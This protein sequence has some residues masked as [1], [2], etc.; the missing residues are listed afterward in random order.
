MDKRLRKSMFETSNSSINVVII[1]KKIAIPIDNTPIYSI[2]KYDSNFINGFFE[3]KSLEDKI[4]YLLII[5]YD[6]ALYNYENP[7]VLITNLVDMLKEKYNIIVQIDKKIDIQNND[8]RGLGNIDKSYKLFDFY[9]KILDD[10]T[11]LERYL[12][13]GTI[14]VGADDSKDFTEYLDTIDRFKYDVFF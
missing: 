13:G 5:A 10:E 2:I 12:F 14:E 4:R 8:I 6:F 11:F 1:P 9:E 7:Q 3:V